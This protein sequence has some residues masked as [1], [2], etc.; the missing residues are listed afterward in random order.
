MFKRLAFSFFAS[1]MATSAMALET[2]PVT[3]INIP[4]PSAG[5]EES[6]ATGWKYSL[7]PIDCCECHYLPAAIKA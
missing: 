5:S 3:A 6:E 2:I 1:L 7:S 4:M